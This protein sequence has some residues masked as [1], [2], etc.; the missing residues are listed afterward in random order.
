VKIQQFKENC[1]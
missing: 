1:Y